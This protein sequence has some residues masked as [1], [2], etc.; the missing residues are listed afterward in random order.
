MKKKEL[1][2]NKVKVK[3]KKNR[4]GDESGE[5]N[6]K[7]TWKEVRKKEK[8][9]ISVLENPV[10]GVCHKSDVSQTLVRM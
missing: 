7:K 10:C 5:R 8:P 1:R 4:N 9:M 6:R 2:E 3:K